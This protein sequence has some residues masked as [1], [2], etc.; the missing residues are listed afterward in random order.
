MCLPGKG[1]FDFE[2]LIKRLKDVGFDGALLIE[3]YTKDYDKEQELR[4]SCDYL[5][6]LLYKYQ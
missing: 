4:D 1:T 3:V 2:T 6:E 5:E